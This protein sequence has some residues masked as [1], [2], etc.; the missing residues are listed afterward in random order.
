MPSTMF[1]AA[2]GGQGVTSLAALYALHRA[3]VFFET[4]L[5]VTHQPDDVRA[6]YALPADPESGSAEIDAGRFGK[7]N[8]VGV[9]TAGQFD[10]VVHDGG[11]RSLIP[12]PGAGDQ[13]TVLV[14]RPC[15]MSLRNIAGMY[16]R[17]HNR[18]DRF[19][20]V[21]EHD[22]ALQHSDIASTVGVP[23]F[24]ITADAAVAVARRIDS[25][26]IGSQLP[27]GLI[28]VFKHLDLARR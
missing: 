26:L 2:K 20:I 6:V 25:G 16:R 8:R 18:P 21:G 19:V 10:H 24:T 28:D 7:H 3:T 12:L 9:N 17:H 11:V 4:V 15:Y 22:R 23:G 14:T 5:V 27:F 13:F 1:Y